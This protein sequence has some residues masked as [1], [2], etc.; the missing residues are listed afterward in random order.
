[1]VKCAPH[2]KD[3]ID[4]SC[5]STEDIDNIAKKLNIVYKTPYDVKTYLNNQSPNCNNDELCLVRRHAPEYMHK[6][7]PIAPES[8]KLNNRAWLS[9]YDIQNC[10]EQYEKEHKDFKFLGVY[11]IDFE[12]YTCSYSS[13]LQS[14]VFFEKNKYGTDKTKFAIVLNLSKT[15]E[16]GTHWVCVFINAD[17]NNPQYGIHYYDSAGKLYPIHKIIKKFM[18]NVKN[19]IDSYNPVKKIKI[20]SNQHTHQYKNTECGTFCIYFITTCLSRCSSSYKEICDH[21]KKDI[22]DRNDEKILEYRKLFFNI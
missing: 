13:V 3:K 7:R 20:T 1:M 16:R 18:T 12:S 4:D 10:I 15:G 19:N 2:V 17:E 21:I 8:W 14:C 6:Y 5:L 9:N 22:C 11:P